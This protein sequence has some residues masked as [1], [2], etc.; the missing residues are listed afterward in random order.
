MIPWTKQFETGSAKLDQQHRI[1][2]DKINLL[3]TQL[4]HTNPTL[5]EV[6]FAAGLVNFLE[7]YSNLHFNGEEKCMEIYRCP[8]HAQNRQEHGRFRVFISN[9]K[10]TCKIEGFKVELLR[11]LHGDMETWI[12]EHMLKVDTQIR[13]CMPASLRDDSGAPTAS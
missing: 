5:A 2:I 3:E 13:P 4:E 7:A 6:E 9:F 11:K 1:L 12:Q 10:K 8:A